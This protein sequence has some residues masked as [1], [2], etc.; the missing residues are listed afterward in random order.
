VDALLWDTCHRNPT[1][2]A[3]RDRGPAPGVQNRSHPVSSLSALSSSASSVLAPKVVT[4]RLS[5]AAR[6]IADRQSGSSES[7]LYML[8]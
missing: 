3:V 6:S 8:N 5:A 4:L 1:G 2:H 7:E